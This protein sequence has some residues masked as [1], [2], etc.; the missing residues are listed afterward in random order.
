[1]QQLTPP[2]SPLVQDYTELPWNVVVDRE[3]AEDE[4]GK[5]RSMKDSAAK[6][7]PGTWSAP[8]TLAGLE[9]ALQVGARV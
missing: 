9:S 8:M 7:P 3:R 5:S 6:D 1:M 2:P 4:L